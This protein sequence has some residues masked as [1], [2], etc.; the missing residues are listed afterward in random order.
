MLEGLEATIVK[1]SELTFENHTFRIDSEYFKKEYLQNIYQIKNFNNG[2]QKLGNFI[3]N[4]TGGATP[5]GAEYPSEGIIFIR[6]QNIMQNYF[7]LNDVVCISKEQNNE[8]KRS[9]LL[10]RDVLLTITGVS[11][12]KSAVVT[13]ELAGANINQHSVKITLNS[14]L[15]P[16]FLSTFLN[17]KFGKLQSDKNVVGITR[18]ALDYQAIK[19]FIIPNLSIDFQYLIEKTI[20]ESEKLIAHSQSLYTQ[21]EQTLLQ[22][23][24]L[25]NWQPTEESKVIKKFS[26]S[27]ALSGRLDAEYYQPKFWEI[28]AKIKTFQNGWK[29]L[30]DCVT[31][32]DENFTPLGNYEYRYIELADIGNSGEITSFTKDLGAN[33]P[34]RARRLV[35]T[36]DVIVSSIEGSLTKCALV[37]EEYDNALCSNGFYVFKSKEILPEVLL[38]IFKSEPFQELMKRRCSG[39]ILTAINSDE[40]K[41][42][43]IPILPMDT[44]KE[45]ANQIQQSFKLR[46][47]S[48]KLIDIAKQ[49]VEI[50]IEQDEQTAMKF[51]KD[52]T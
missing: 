14:N 16:Y 33:L 8:I 49:A 18:P 26:Q 5:L 45:L 35:K 39:T 15:S 31:M 25:S 32:D 23:L 1:Y 27:F 43:P 2:F 52:N 36:N 13:K 46:Q 40:L 44:Q 22:I 50:A 29:Y 34:S 10:E 42:I 47:E 6:V 4:M 17:S 12:G 19:E 41:T 51:I 24:G 3:K 7:N 21:A 9:Q 30:S 11:Y 38:L 20:I 37:T 28:E 48:S